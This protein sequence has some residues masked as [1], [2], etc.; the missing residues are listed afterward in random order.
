[1]MNGTGMKKYTYY[2]KL[3]NTFE[4]PIGNCNTKSYQKAIKA[5]ARERG[6]SLREF[7]ILYQV[8]SDSTG[9]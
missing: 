1:M 8:V 2:K 6:L 9:S 7:V 5:F 4:E 3:D